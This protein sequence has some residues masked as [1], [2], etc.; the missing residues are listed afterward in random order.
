M[1]GFF[2]LLNR[3]RADER[4]VFAVIFG[5]LAIVL[6]AMAGAAVDY[7]SMETAR[8]KMQIALD[9]AA[10]GLAPKIYTQTEAQLATT[11][12]EL[13]LERLNDDSLTVTVDWADAT[14]ATGTLKLKGT[15]TVPMAFVTLVGIPSMT[16]SIT[17]E[18]TR[19][20]VNLE[21]A[22]ALDTTG[23]M[24]T[25]GITT[26]QTALATLIP[27]VVHDE[28][29]PTYS[30]MALVPYSTAVN[31]GSAY[32]DEARG[33]IPAS[34]AVTSAAWWN[35]EA[36]ISGA[37]KTNPIVIT[38]S[39]NHGYA[40]GDVVYIS[41]VSG[42]TQLNGNT[43]KVGTTTNTTFQLKTMANN[44][45]NGTS[46]YSTYS[47]SSSDKVKRC[48]LSTC[49]IVITSP[50]HG[51][52]DGDYVRFTDFSSYM[53]RLNNRAYSA[54][55]KLTKDTFKVPVDGPSNSNYNQPST[56][57]A[58]GNVW[59]TDYGCKF[60]KIGNSTYYTATASCAT[61][62][63]TNSFTD[64]APSTT[65]LSINYTSNG[66]CSG[67]PVQM[68][69]LTSSK[70]KLNAYTS[71]GAL[72]ASGNTAGQIGTAWAWYLVSPNFAELFDD[73][74]ATVGGDFESKPAAYDAPNTL[75]IVI[76][77]T[78]GAYNTEYCK[79]VDTDDVGCNAPDGTT[80][81]MSGAFGQAEDLCHNMKQEDVVVYTVGFNLGT[82]GNAVDVLR[83][84]ASDSS[85]AKLANDSA[86]LVAAFREIGEN[87]SDLRLSM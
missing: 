22:V 61:E 56:G 24:G 75:K 38:T 74:A 49:E 57:S 33:A 53:T 32:A 69:P 51:F 21:V 9:S 4:G 65:P 16:T 55:T 45:V 31:V 34:K 81:T 80:G 87:I 2:S 20:S 83:N 40:T 71:S 48:I 26:L 70:T 18:A 41:G 19:G 43:Y 3:F 11:A 14:T 10:L 50:N 25:T 6:V 37:S 82:T 36:N 1:R 68:Q 60:Y 17:S 59:C 15:I 13:V 29:T 27:L 76:I 30:K 39:A 54:I 52:V 86:G 63:M 72:S 67:N 7:T 5:L 44:N 73:A 85:K 66:S 47:S 23:S 42:M 77:M 8:A 78:D 64:V 12:Q 35:S 84:C 62:R 46:G 58:T 28:Q 79:G